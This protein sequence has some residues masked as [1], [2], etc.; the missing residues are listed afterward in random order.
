MQIHNFLAVTSL[1]TGALAG[2]NCKGN[3]NCGG[4]L[5]KLTDILSKV[6]SLPQ[7]MYFVSTG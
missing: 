6:R 7:G 5:C 3:S 1:A 4:T 2:I